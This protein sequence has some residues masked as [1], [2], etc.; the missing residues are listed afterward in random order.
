M[1]IQPKLL[2]VTETLD[3]DRIGGRK[4]IPV[5]FRLIVATNRN[6]E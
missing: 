1:K 6:L 3:V 2:D 4:P 5:D